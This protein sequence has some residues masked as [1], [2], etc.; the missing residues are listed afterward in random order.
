MSRARA[1]LHHPDLD[2][3]KAGG[4]GPVPHVGNL[5]GLALAAVWR[6]PD[7]PVAADRVAAVPETRRHAGVR[8][9][10]QHSPELAAADFPGNLHSKLK[11]QPS[12]VDAPALV[13]L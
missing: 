11:I 2:I 4:G 1:S 12:I 8:R 13:C 7:G 6:A 5:A 3:A 9:V 10:F